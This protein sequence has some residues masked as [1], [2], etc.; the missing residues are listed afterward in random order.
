[1]SSKEVVAIMSVRRRLKLQKNFQF[2]ANLWKRVL[3]EQAIKVEIEM[4]NAQPPPQHLDQKARGSHAIKYYYARRS[5]RIKA[6]RR[7]ARARAEA[8]RQANRPK[9]S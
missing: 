6:I 9:A 8:L 5:A 3:I 1:M 2:Q 7:A 4:G